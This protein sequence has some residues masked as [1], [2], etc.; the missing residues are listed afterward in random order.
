MASN[1]VQNSGYE[2]QA[3][4]VNDKG[5]VL[6]YSWGFIQY[7]FDWMN[8][9]CR[10]S[11]NIPKYMTLD[12]R[13]KSFEA[14]PAANKGPSPLA[15]ATS[16]FY[17]TNNADITKCFSCS[18]QLYCWKKGDSPLMEHSKWRPNCSFLKLAK[19]FQFVKRANLLLN[20]KDQR[21]LTTD[22]AEELHMLTKQSDMPDYIINPL[23]DPEHPCVVC[24]AQERSVLF[25]PC[26][27]V[28]CCLWCAP[29]LQACPICKSPLLSLMSIKIA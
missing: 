24:F 7:P 15:L 18:L 1:Q 25:Q 4:F 16:G 20:K 21:E 17:Y 2:Q 22:E 11:T 29:L 8:N 6:C 26:S 3:H 9:Y 13:L 10:H 12:S 27:H 19:G 5:G 23:Q 28:A 14:W